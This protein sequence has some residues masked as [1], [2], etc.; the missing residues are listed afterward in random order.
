[1]NHVAHTPPPGAKLLIVIPTLDY[2]GAE[3]HTTHQINYWVQQG[4]TP[5]LLVLNQIKALQ[6]VLLLPAQY[7]TE[8]NWP[9]SSIQ[10][11]SIIFIR[12]A[13]KQISS[14]I[15]KNKITHVMAHLPIAHYLLRWVKL[16]HRLLRQQPFTLINYH[17]SLEYEH[18]PMNTLGK[19]L[20]NR[21]NS[22]LAHLADD[23]S[24]C[25]SRAVFNNINNHFFLKNPHIIYNA[26]PY[27]PMSNHE[28]LQYCRQNNIA[29]APYTILLPGRLHP[30]KGHVFF[31]SV[32]A[33]VARRLN[34][35]PQDVQV[36]IAG[37]G[38]NEPAIKQQIEQ[39][40]LQ[41]FF[42]FTGTIP[43]TLLLS[44]MR[45]ANLTIV[46]SLSEG[47]PVVAIEALMQQVL[48]LCSDAGGLPEV[49]TDGI[50]GFVFPTLNA[51]I[52][53]QKLIYLYQ[54][55]NQQLINPQTLLNDFNARFSLQ[56]HMQKLNQLLA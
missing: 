40:A 16:K 26:L 46:P 12:N 32:F 18:S 5:Y 25:V 6:D 8:L 30:V 49:I 48:I 47:M 27:N 55:R 3:V 31:V 41:H 39:H 54:N 9:Y 4:F 10:T 13:V 56:A 21:F 44:F 43:Q 36:I 42:S 23:V 45:L 19:R 2:G 17:H 11:L 50:N 24:V 53:A 51:E 22:L 29:T 37:G 1:M 33:A 35:T 34:W 52:C 15:N 7:R 14:H 38:E 20:F 28:A